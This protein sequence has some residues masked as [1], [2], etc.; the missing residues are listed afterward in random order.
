MPFEFVSASRDAMHKM[1]AAIAL[2]ALEFTAQVASFCC[3]SGP[4]QGAVSVA[5]ESRK[6]IDLLE[7]LSIF[8][9]VARALTSSLD[10]DSILRSIMQQME[11]FF[12]PESW[13]LLIVD[14]ERN[15]LYYAV[16]AGHSAEA[17]G[18]VRIPMGH[19]M[20]GWVAEHGEPLIISGEEIATRRSPA[21]SAPAFVYS[22]ISVPLRSRLRTLG[23]IQL[24]NYQ[25][26]TLTDYTITFL[27][28]L[29]DYAAIA[30]E[31]ARAVER[32]QELT[33]TDDCT[34]LYNARYLQAM[35]KAE[36][37]RSRRFGS[38]FSILFID[39]DR[40]KQIN[41]E[42]GHLTGS[43]LLAEFAFGLRSN[44]RAV[45]LAFRY[46]GDEFVVLL[47]QTGKQAAIGV[48]QRLIEWLRSARF[49]ASEELGLQVLASFGI[50]TFPDDAET[51]EDLV[52]A[53]DAMM[54]AVKNTTR[55]AIAA[56]QVGRI[57]F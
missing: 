49:L 38:T 31:N 7:E 8:H 55:N 44:L 56:A 17:L 9:R 5:D 41:D 53:A 19:G 10:L 48:A 24:F 13:S 36:A 21:E 32:I 27:H 16:V 18:D 57:T 34:Q 51:V 14:P 29:S 4:A 23:V 15:D 37:E 46:G 3:T 20:A 40:F 12:R 33:I 52:H 11:Q 25:L 26:A 54:Y 22:A 2:G 1:L 50:A 6:Q 42:H 43:R 39:L 45:D 28:I 35:L 47:P 30:I